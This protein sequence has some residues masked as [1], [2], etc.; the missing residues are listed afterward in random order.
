MKDAGVR[1][2]DNSSARKH[3]CS[4]E[5]TRPA[6]QESSLPR[7][8][9]HPVS[10]GWMEEARSGEQASNGALR[11]SAVLSTVLKSTLSPAPSWV[12]PACSPCSDRETEQAGA[13][14]PPV[15]RHF[16]YGTF[17]LLPRRHAQQLQI[18]LV[19]FPVLE[20]RGPCRSRIYRAVLVHTARAG[21]TSSTSG[22]S[23]LSCRRVRSSYSRTPVSG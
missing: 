5:Y 11:L 7:C 21:T 1:R 20:G 10:F 2:P 6:H 9:C 14:R 13:T 18:R 16:T 8:S 19:F 3:K 23:L 4:P 15:W 22:E 12:S 17:L